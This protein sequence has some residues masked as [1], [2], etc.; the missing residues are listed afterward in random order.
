MISGNLNFLEPS[1]PLQ[2]C[3]RTALPLYHFVGEVHVADN[4][5]PIWLFLWAFSE[6]YSLCAGSRISSMKLPK[7]FLL[8][9]VLKCAVQEVR[10]GCRSLVRKPLRERV[11]SE[12]WTFV[13]SKCKVGQLLNETPLLYG[14]SLYFTK[15]EDVCL[16]LAIASHVS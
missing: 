1:G 15:G 7:Q 10:H 6:H 14:V 4:L 2:A 3:N 12:E 11:P 16:S 9:S 8:N 13:V 5:K